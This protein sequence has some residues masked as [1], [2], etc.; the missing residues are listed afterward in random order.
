MI[1]RTGKNDQDRKPRAYGEAFRA[2]AGCRP[3]ETVPAC[4][5]TPPALVRQPPEAPADTKAAILHL[6]RW[7]PPPTGR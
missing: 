7:A 4:S 2:C 6:D 1:G 5:R 3:P